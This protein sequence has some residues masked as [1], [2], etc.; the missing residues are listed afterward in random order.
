MEE[1]IYSR[2]GMVCPYCGHIHEYWDIEDKSFYEYGTFDCV[3]CNQ[4]FTSTCNKLYS[5]V[6]KRYKH[7]EQNI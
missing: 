1:E 4:T 5:W 2:E 7:N 3:A 6:T